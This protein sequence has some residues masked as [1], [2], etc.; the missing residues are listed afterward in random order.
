MKKKFQK[1]NVYSVFTGRRW[2]TGVS[3]LELIIYVAI[4]SVVSLVIV[5]IFLVVLRGKDL[6]NARFEVSQNAR[7]ATEK[8]RQAVFDASSV[9]ISGSC[10]F[11]ILNITTGAATSSIFINSGILQISDASGTSEITANKVI[12]TSTDN[13]LF[14]IISNPAPAKDTIQ[15][16]LKIMYNSQGRSDLNI[17]Q[18]QEITASLR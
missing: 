13:C 10:P 15:T 12:A 2:Q 6:A 5:Q 3:L 18:S 14:T 7:F 11:N 8:I 9:S 4:F 1:C 16:K 17:S